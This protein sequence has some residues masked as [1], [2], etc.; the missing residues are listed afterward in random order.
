[1]EVRFFP[2][3]DPLKFVRR[4][5]ARVCCLRP[6]VTE[7]GPV[8]RFRRPATLGSYV[9]RSDSCV[10]GSPPTSPFPSGRI[11]RTPRK[12]TR[13]LLSQPQIRRE[14]PVNLSILMTGGKETNQDV[15]SSGERRGHGSNLKSG[16]PRIF[17]IVVL[18]SALTGASSRYK[19]SGTGATRRVTVPYTR[20]RRSSDTCGR[21]GESGCL[22]MQPK[23]VIDLIQS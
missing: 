13:G 12:E 9:S 11:R 2:R 10:V 7:S 3:A 6:N 5:V 21:F 23:R 17:R 4:P 18:R 22:G 8:N 15:L 19:S 20:L 1:M 14:H 16:G